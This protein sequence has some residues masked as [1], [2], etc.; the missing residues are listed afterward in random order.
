MMICLAAVAI[1][2]RPDEHWRS[3]VMPDTLDRAA[4]AE[5][6]L[7]ADI[8]ELR[9]LRQHRAPHDIVDLAGVDPGALDRRLQRECARASAP[10]SR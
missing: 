8:A 2:I 6:D 9:A 7:A 3:I 4:G 5:R 10:A 1:A